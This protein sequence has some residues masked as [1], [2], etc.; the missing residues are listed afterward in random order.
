MPGFNRK[1]ILAVL[2]GVVV[3]V[4]SFAAAVP[5]SAD[6]TWTLNIIMGNST[7]PTSQ[8][9][10]GNMT[11]VTIT[12]SDMHG[13]HDWSGVPLW[14]L[15]AK[16]DDSDPDT[17]NDALAATNYSIKATSSDNYIRC[18]GPTATGTTIARNNDV[19]LADTMDGGPLPSDIAPLKVVGL[20]LISS[21][22]VSKTTSIELV[23]VVKAVAGSNGSIT[24]SGNTMDID[25][26]V[27]VSFGANQTLNMVPDSGYCVDTLTVDSI[28]VTPA[29][30]YVFNCVTA[31]HAMNATF[32]AGA[33]WDLNGD[34]ICNIG[35]VVKVGLK[36]G[37]TGSPGWILEDI[38]KDGSIN[39]GDV[40]MLGLYWGQTW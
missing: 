24:P 35:D 32:T 20:N 9:E 1:G 26:V 3:V 14:M 36:W 15:A 16:I 38:N 25:G 10:F 13:T 7:Y 30:S 4:A 5:A 33:A 31:N 40:V 11:H 2:I 39:I 6:D 17:F 21:H 22:F 23:Y 28:P 27:G 37:Q 29:Y 8:A 34:H 12:V 19:I 18:V